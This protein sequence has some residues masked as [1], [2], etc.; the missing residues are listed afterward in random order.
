MHKYAQETDE[1]SGEVRFLLSIF[2][3]KLWAENSR[4]GSCIKSCFS[5][6]LPLNKKIDFWKIR[7]YKYFVFGLFQLPRGSIS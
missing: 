6:I 1:S 4:V 7:R 3:K 2:K 5:K